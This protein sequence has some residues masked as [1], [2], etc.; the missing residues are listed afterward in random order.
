MSIL[1]STGWRAAS[2]RWTPGRAVFRTLTSVRFALL[3]IG[4]LVLAALAGVVIPQEPPEA[5]DFPSL[6]SGFLAEQQHRFGAFAGP[7]ERVGLFDIFHSPWFVTML[8]VLLAAVAV[9][10]WSRFRPSWRQ[11]TRPQLRVGDQYFEHARHRAATGPA[12]AATMTSVLKRHHYRVT[13]M[14]ASP[15][16]TVLYADRFR[17]SLMGTFLSHL[18]LVIFLV[19]GLISALFNQSTRVLVAEGAT[20]AVFNP[21]SSHHMQLQL[22]DFHRVV[23][24]DGR[25]RELYSD[26]VISRHGE[27]VARGQ[28]SINRPLT[29]DG[30]AFHQAAF[31]DGG[32][33]LDVRSADGRL[34]FSDVL[35]LTEQVAVPHLSIRSIDGTTLFDGTA[36]PTLFAADGTGIS[37]VALAGLAKPVAV[38]ARWSDDANGGTWTA[39]FSGIC[40]GVVEVPAGR[41]QACGNYE[42]SVQ[43]VGIAFAGRAESLPAPLGGSLVEL[44]PGA[45]GSQEMV[46]VTPDGQTARLASGAA[47]ALG[48]LNVTFQGPRMYS[49]F[50]VRRDP[51]TRF[52]WVATAM[53]LLGLGATFY[54]PYRRLWVRFDS[55]S[56]AAA[57]IAP[58]GSDYSRALSRLLDEGKKN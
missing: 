49:G 53:L 35:P 40:D 43:S 6:R 47:Q 11:L 36:P 18:S 38:A 32:A 19:G 50:T 1:A 26:V 54:F 27:E 23:D 41:V 48:G 15:D 2:G 8:G 17:W 3:L 14:E 20:A 57:G 31:A 21:G 39:A 33:A 45:G 22:L 13:V 44:A 12:D 16:R 58:A 52:I 4:V 25:E 28:V 55:H 30:Y 51:G 56:T 24:V 9:C 42:L 5:A 10:S 37:M 46:L 34:L 7:M 29:V